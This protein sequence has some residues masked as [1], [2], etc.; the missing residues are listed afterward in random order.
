MTV[1]IDLDGTIASWGHEG[2]HVGEWIEGAQDALRTLLGEG[3]RLIIHTCRVTW[4]A[5]GEW[6]AVA[7]FLRTGGFVPALVVTE[8]D[9]RQK[10]VYVDE[11]FADSLD[12]N[13]Q[14]I[15][16]WLGKGKP[17]ADA[18]VDDRGIRFPGHWSPELLD[19]IRLLAA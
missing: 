15:G 10:W 16:I 5:G 3:H 11:D 6:K 14:V 1:A 18:Y 8:D 9:Q 12:N 13:A 4:P 2:Y 7:D 19:Q 17:I